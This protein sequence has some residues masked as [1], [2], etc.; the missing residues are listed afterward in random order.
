MVYYDKGVF[1]KIDFVSLCEAQ[2]KLNDAN[3]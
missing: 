1:V 3:V 2:Q